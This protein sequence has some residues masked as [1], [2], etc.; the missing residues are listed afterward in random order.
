MPPTLCVCVCVWGGG[1]GEGIDFGLDL[2]GLKD[3]KQTRTDISLSNQKE[4]R[5][6]F[7]V[8]GQIRSKVKEC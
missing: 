2:I 4:L 1:G 8:Q 5:L 7:G 3:L 6:C